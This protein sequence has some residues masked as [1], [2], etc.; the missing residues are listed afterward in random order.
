MPGCHPCRT[1]LSASGR[2]SAQAVVAAHNR[3]SPDPATPPKASTWRPSPGGPAAG[4]DRPAGAACGRA[5]L[6][7]AASLVPEG[8]LLVGGSPGR[9]ASGSGGISGSASSATGGGGIS[10]PGGAAISG[11]GSTPLISASASATSASPVSASEG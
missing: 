5:V 4:G 6:S 1:A 2:R 11:G 10:G 3:V 7:Y 8:G 9:S